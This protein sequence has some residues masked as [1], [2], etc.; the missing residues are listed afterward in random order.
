L[1]EILEIKRIRIRSVLRLVFLFHAFAGVLLG[2]LIVGAWGVVSI[3][4]LQEIVPAFLG[5]V[6]DPDSTSILLLLSAIA[7][8]FGA[9]GALVWALIILLY[10]VVAGF[11]RGIQVEVVPGRAGKG[12]TAADGG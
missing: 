6:G 8:A 1:A 10:N 4:G 9:L 5:N 2:L 12:G 11:S 7:L 3:F